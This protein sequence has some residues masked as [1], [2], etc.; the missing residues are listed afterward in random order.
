[1]TH[2]GRTISAAEARLNAA[3]KMDRCVDRLL[4]EM[5]IRICALELA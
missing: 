5:T 1:M 2:I 3:R 4:L